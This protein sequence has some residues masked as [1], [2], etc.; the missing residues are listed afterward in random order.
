MA[1]DT[2]TITVPAGAEVTMNFDNQD[3]GIPHNVAVYDSPLRSEAIFVG[4]IITGVARPPTRSR[5]CP[6]P[7]PTTSSVT[8]T[9]T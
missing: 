2:D 6:S 4:E 3:Q 7:G 8:F 5:P 9:P 1:F